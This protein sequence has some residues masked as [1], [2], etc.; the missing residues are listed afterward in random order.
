VDDERIDQQDPVVVDLIDSDTPKPALSRR[1]TRRRTE[2]LSPEQLAV[3]RR[4]VGIIDG[5]SSG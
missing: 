2:P 1:R 5:P 3:L 4:Q